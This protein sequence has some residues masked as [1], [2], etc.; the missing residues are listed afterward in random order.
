MTNE[1]KKENQAA[2][3][4]RA[5]IDTRN[6]SV[7]DK[8]KRPLDPRRESKDFLS[9]EK[10]KRERLRDQDTLRVRLVRSIILDGDHQDE[11]K[12]VE[13][14]RPLAH[15]LVGEGSAVHH[16]NPDFPPTPEESALTTSNRMLP[17]DSRD[18]QTGSTTRPAKTVRVY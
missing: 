7:D 17:A 8:G 16:E 13:V 4:D 10:E 18:P 5:G 1:Q 6:A 14:P 9:D 12:V 15:R 3:D 2:A 11:G